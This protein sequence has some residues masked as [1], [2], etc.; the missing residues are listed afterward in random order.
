MQDG[1]VVAGDGVAALRRGD[2]VIVIYQG[3]STLAR[4]SWAFDRAEEALAKHPE[5]IIVLML[6]QAS[7]RPPDAATRAL[8]EAGYKRHGQRLRMNITV[9]EGSPFH[10]SVVRMVLST[11]FMLSGRTASHRVVDNLSEAARVV[12]AV[13]SAATPAEDQIMRDVAK[14]RSALSETPRTS[15]AA[16]RV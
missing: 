2:L 13:A 16:P 7:S 15:G 1:L 11:A 12:S 14:V 6:I 9:P 8:L 5:G 3:S 4:S 10:R